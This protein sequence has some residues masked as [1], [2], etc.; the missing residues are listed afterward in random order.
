MTLP[1]L[2]PPR[3]PFFSV[4]DLQSFFTKGGDHQ[5]TFQVALLISDSVVSESV[6][7]MHMASAPSS[8]LQIYCSFLLL[9]L[10]IDGKNS[11]KFEIGGLVMVPLGCITD[12]KWLECPIFVALSFYFFPFDKMS[13]FYFV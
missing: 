7:L 10:V 13:G 12:L 8:K 6:P 3:I 4:T 1:P 2:G 5:S 9:F 11:V